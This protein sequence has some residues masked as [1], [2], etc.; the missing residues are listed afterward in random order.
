MPLPITGATELDDWPGG[1]GLKSWYETLRTMLQPT[2]K[3]LGFGAEEI[4]TRRFMSLEDD[5]IAI[6][7]RTGDD[8]K[9]MS[10]V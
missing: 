6:W 1:I 2:L 4:T 5:A 10:V 7:Q 8:G 9:L 3:S